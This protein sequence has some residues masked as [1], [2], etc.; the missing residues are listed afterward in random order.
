MAHQ[1]SGPGPR[2]VSSP[3]LLALF[4]LLFGICLAEAW[5]A[6]GFLWDSV[7]SIGSMTGFYLLWG[8][9]IACSAGVL[10]AVL[11]R[12]LGAAFG[13]GAAEK[14]GDGEETAPPSIFWQPVV[15]VQSGLA[16]VVGLGLGVVADRVS[17]RALTR[18]QHVRLETLAREQDP[19]GPCA[20]LQ[21]ASEMLHQE[22]V[23]R[24]SIRVVGYL[25]DARLQVAECAARAAVNVACRMRRSVSMLSE[26]GLPT[27]GAWEGRLL[28]RLS[29]RLG[30]RARAQAAGPRPGGAAQLLA[31]LARPGDFDWFAGLLSRSP[32]SE[33]DASAAAQGL[34][35]IGGIPAAHALADALQR[36]GPEASAWLVWGL[37]AIGRRTRPEP[38]G[39]TLPEEVLALCRHV[40]RQ[41]E[42][43]DDATLCGAVAAVG[44]FRHAGVTEDL[45]RLFDSPRG[46]VRCP[47][48]EVRPPVGPPETPSTD[49][50]LQALLLDI[51]AG[52]G[53]GNRTLRTWLLEAADR[54]D[55]PAD[56]VSRIRN[57][58]AEAQSW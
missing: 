23:E 48:T 45:V 54:T 43:M 8:G 24:Y 52:V 6:G 47:R 26:R 55:L 50:E 46:S 11:S 39:G 22:D 28:S 9:T 19:E 33:S 3:I 21:E 44:E 31:C 1:G 40:L 57:M 42:P 18:A 7:S 2:R 16:V 14:R 15:L 38:G 27:S 10:A 49:I 5:F 56:L 17:D 41:A 4:L 51:L 30:P 58:A 53:G 29:D 37:A 13:W 25:D 36:A 34:A 12:F 20:F 32:L 35:S